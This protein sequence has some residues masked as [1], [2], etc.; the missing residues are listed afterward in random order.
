MLIAGKKKKTVEHPINKLYPVKYFDGFTIHA[1]DT[2]DND[3]EEKLQ[4]SQTSKGNFA[5]D[6]Y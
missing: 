5:T 2:F 3:P 4:C 6:I 1:V